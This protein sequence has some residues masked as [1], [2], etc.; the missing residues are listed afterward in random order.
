MAKSL[1]RTSLV[2]LVAGLFTRPVF[3]IGDTGLTAAAA[4]SGLS[5][6]GSDIPTFIGKVLGSAL[7]FT[8]TIFFYFGYY[9][10]LDVDDLRRKR[11][12]R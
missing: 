4:P 6:V 1:L 9:C 12:A 11:R 8:G 5:S 7:G 10:W 2:A 3:A